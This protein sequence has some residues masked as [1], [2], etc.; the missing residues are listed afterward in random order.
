[1]RILLAEDDPTS[2]LLASMR[3]R[4]DGHAVQEVCDGES[5]LHAAHKCDFDL[6]L[7]DVHVPVMDGLTATRA[8]RTL[9]TDPDPTVRKRSQVPIVAVTALAMRGD[10][11]R[12]LE[13]G[14][15]R[16]LTKPL[17]ADR[18]RACLDEFARSGW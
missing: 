3:F 11:E 15:N 17:R 1:L 4:R 5:A 16:H 13:A 8:I 14:M 6:V 12:C 7:M 2:R 10:T 18:L 9:A